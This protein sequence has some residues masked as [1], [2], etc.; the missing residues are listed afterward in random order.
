MNTGFL[1]VIRPFDDRFLTTPKDDRYMK[2][3]EWYVEHALQYIL[4]SARYLKPIL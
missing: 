4:T 1:S 2:S 3:A